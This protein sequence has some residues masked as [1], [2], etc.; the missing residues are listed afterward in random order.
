[1]L[2]N[3]FYHLCFFVILF[4]CRKNSTN[5]ERFHASISKRELYHENDP[6]VDRIIQDMQT[7][8]ILHVGEYNFLCKLI[9]LI[10]S[11]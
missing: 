3:V 7:L 10:F 11:V 5:L 8:P 4:I 1:M 9:I 6:V 2:F